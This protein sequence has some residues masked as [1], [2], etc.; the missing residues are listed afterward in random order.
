MKRQ[1]IIGTFLAATL[2]GGSYGTW[3]VS[4]ATTRPAKGMQEGRGPT[5]EMFPEKRLARMARELGLSDAQQ[6]QIK[7]IFAAEREKNGPLMEKMKA[8]RKQ[9]HDAA[10]A[11]PF[12]EAAVRTVA[13]N[14][15]Q[16]EVELAVS[17]ARIQS[18][19]NGILTPEQRQKLE[20]LRPPMG[21]GER[22]PPPPDDEPLP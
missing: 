22:L 2:A 17:R 10:K 4:A 12:D 7:A 16:V 18:Q 13:T 5:G 14:Q 20:K 9:L 11:T 15:A 8:Y 19:I 6:A 3:E 21:K 1:I